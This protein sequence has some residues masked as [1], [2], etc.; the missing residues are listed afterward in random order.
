MVFIHDIKKMDRPKEII[1]SFVGFQIINE[2]SSLDAEF[3]YSFFGVGFKRIKILPEWEINSFH[4]RR[5]ILLRQA[6]G[7]VIQGG[8]QVMQHISSYYRHIEGNYITS[9]DC[10]ALTSGIRINIYSGGWRL[11]FDEIVNSRFEFLDMGFGPFNL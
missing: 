3:L 8:S 6:I 5:A 10:V 11:Y 2:A 7:Q 1:P 4:A 9:E